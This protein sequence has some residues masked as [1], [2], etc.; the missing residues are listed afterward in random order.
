MADIGLVLG[1]GGAKGA[2]EAGAWKALCNVGLNNHIRIYSGASIGA[3]NCAFIKLMDCD[4]FSDFW[5]KYNLEKIFVYGGVNYG[6]I[7]EIIMNLRKGEKIT[8]DGLFSRDGLIKLFEKVNIGK[9]ENMKNDFYVNVV[10][11]SEI[12]EEMRLIK[13]AL[14]WYDGRS[15]GKTEYI[16]LK[17]KNAEFIQDMLLATSALPI[18][19]PPVEIG[20]DYYID[21]GIN[22]NLPIHPLYKRGFR[23]IIAISTT[24]LNKHNVA[25]KFPLA[26]IM[27]IHP[28]RYL[29]NL[30]SGTLN[31]NKQKIK[32]T[33]KLGYNDALNV[34]KKSNLLNY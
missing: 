1:G 2:Y 13:P 32:Q 5:L 28:S 16:N 19:Y 29:G 9:L 25:R 30:F 33:Y 10:N 17:N 21:G 34:I 14:D 12:P 7:I 26:E 27:L 15:T 18:I 11:I 20:G 3:L 4:E 31:F 8:F 23:K 24:R 22:D 6:E